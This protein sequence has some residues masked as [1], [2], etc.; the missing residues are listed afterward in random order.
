MDL[1]FTVLALVVLG[2]VAQFLVN[3]SILFRKFRKEEVI[4]RTLESVKIV[5]IDVVAHQDN[6]LYLLYELE[7]NKF[8]TQVNRKEDIVWTLLS[9]FP[10]CAVD[11]FFVKTNT[12]VVPLEQ[13]V[14]ELS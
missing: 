13:F 6:V 3:F 1:I 8:L 2:A 14:E 11:E 10:S 4:R 9:R 12:N 5:Q 7:K